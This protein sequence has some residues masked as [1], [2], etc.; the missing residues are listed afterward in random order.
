MAGNHWIRSDR[1]GSNRIGSDRLI[2]WRRWLFISSPLGSFCA[3]QIYGGLPSEPNAIVWRR[4]CFDGGDG[5]GAL[6][7]SNDL[8]FKLGSAPGA[9]R[10]THLARSCYS[11][12]FLG[13]GG[14]RAAP[15]WAAPESGRARDDRDRR[16]RATSGSGQGGTNFTFGPRASSGPRG[17]SG[18][19]GSH[20]LGEAESA[21]PTAST[22]RR[23]QQQL[24]IKWTYLE[25]RSA[26]LLEFAAAARHGRSSA[27]SG[28][29]LGADMATTPMGAAESGHQPLSGTG[30]TSRRAP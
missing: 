25:D 29:H 18:D 2:G 15:C 13:S 26:N 1:I 27:T 28:G 7:E 3:P 14:G 6:S 17:E 19:R 21:S 10:A 16:R 23:Q 5:R 11:L 4:F 9:G 24:E 30:G 8:Q 12:E 20:Q 22:R